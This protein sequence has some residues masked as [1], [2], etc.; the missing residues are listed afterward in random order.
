MGIAYILESDD[1]E[2]LERRL[3]NLQILP[4]D[5]E[6]FYGR[7]LLTV[8]TCPKDYGNETDGYS[9]PWTHPCGLVYHPCSV[10]ALIRECRISPAGKM[11]VP[12]AAWSLKID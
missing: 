4:T 3:S 5:I 8:S 12:V 6:G 1:I 11:I 10:L 2:S 9:L 7:T